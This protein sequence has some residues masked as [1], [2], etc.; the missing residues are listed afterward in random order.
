MHSLDSPNR[1]PKIYCV[2]IICSFIYGGCTSGEKPI[3]QVPNQPTI[4]ENLISQENRLEIAKNIRATVQSD[5]CI[6]DIVLGLPEQEWRCS[7]SQTGEIFDVSPNSLEEP[8]KQTQATKEIIEPD[9]ETI[10]WDEA[11]QYLD[12]YINVCGPV[13]DSYF[14]ASTDGQPTFLN[15]GREYPDPDRFTVLIWGSNLES[16][17]FNPDEFYFGKSICVEGKIVEYD[18]M[19]EI[20]VRRPEQIEVR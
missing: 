6:E 13:V 5:P 20:V 18:G 17:S 4:P 12:Q 11:Y 7:N 9:L 2:L 14:A 15:L 10:Q 3:T 19:Y 1:A 8:V 16:F